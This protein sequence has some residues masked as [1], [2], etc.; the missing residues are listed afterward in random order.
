MKTNVWILDFS[1]KTN[2]MQIII[3]IINNILKN[4]MIS[5][6]MSNSRIFSTHLWNRYWGLR[7]QNL[8]FVRNRSICSWIVVLVMTPL[9]CQPQSREGIVVCLCCSAIQ[10]NRMYSRSSEQCVVR[11]TLCSLSLSDSQPVHQLDV[12]RE[13]AFAVNGSE[14]SSA[15]V[16][17]AQ[18]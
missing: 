6:E 9:R 14:G 13:Q 1:C 3:A 17:N 12:T 15:E 10:S 11:L 7:E 2:E 16:V 4:N 18:N 5:N 8:S